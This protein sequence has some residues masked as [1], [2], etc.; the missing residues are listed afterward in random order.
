MTSRE[1]VAGR[2]CWVLGK[3]ALLG[4]ALGGMACFSSGHVPPPANAIRIGALLP[5]SGQSASMGVTLESALRLATSVVNESG[6]IDDRSL[7]LEIGDSAS[8]DTTGTANAH[9]LIDPNPMPFFIGPEEPGIATR[10]TP[11]ITANQMTDINPSLTSLPIHD[12]TVDAAWYKLTPSVNYLAC[13]IA[14]QIISDGVTTASTLT[15]ADSYSTSFADAFRQIFTALGGMSVVSA[16]IPQDSAQYTFALHHLTTA[17]VLI[18]TPATATQLLQQ[19]LVLGGTTQWYLGPALNNPE[20]LRNLPAG[21][22][23]GTVGFSPDFGSQAQSFDSYLVGSTSASPLPGAHYYFDAVALLALALGESVWAGDGIPDP[24]AFK[25]HLFNVS[26]AGGVVVTFDQIA[27]GLS[28]VKTGQK[29]QYQGAAGTNILDDQG[30]STQSEIAI[31][32]ISSTSFE[33]VGHQ[34][35]SASEAYPGVASP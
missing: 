17:V 12:S 16:Q 35:C 1:T 25:P 4:L 23:E 30:D 19:D 9:A 14:K 7:Y 6:G 24:A 31:W 32:Q 26:S 3:A 22:L 29:V 8:D 27:Q 34:Q 18:T 33:I 15:D 5:F 28:L 11:T 20:L 13:A 10:L 2:A 21:A